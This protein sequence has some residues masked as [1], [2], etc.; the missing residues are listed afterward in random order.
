[1]PS[2]SVVLQCVLA[3]VVVGLCA[4]H[5]TG[6]RGGLRRAEAAWTMA[7]ALAL[8]A[9]SL[10]NGLL[11]VAPAQALEPL[12]LA[13]YLFV[14]V[15]L[16]VSV[17][18]VRLYA[19][20]Q[21]RAAPVVAMVVW[22]VAGAVLWFSTDLVFAHRWT[23]GLPV[24]GTL[25]T[26]TLLVPLLVVARTVQR[27]LRGRALDP[28]GGAVAL[29]ATASAVVLITSAVPPPSPLTELL[30]G[31]WVVPLVAVLL[32]VT[33]SRTAAVRRDAQRRAEMRDVLS[34][35]TNDAWLLRSPERTLERAVDEARR[36]LD[37]VTI[38]GTIRPLSR[39]RFVTELFSGSGRADDP[40]EAS[41]LRDLARVVSAA[42][43]RHALSTR[44]ERA[45][46]TDSLTGLHNRHA[47]DRHLQGALDRANVERSRVA[48]LF[49]DLD[50][51]KI[52]NDRHGHEW[53]DML[54]VHLAGHLR[55]VL[56]DGAFVARQG[57]DEFVA[58]L[59]RA[60]GGAAL[61]A[62]ARRLRD[63]FEGP[64]ESGARTAISVGL[65]VWRPG[66]VVDPAGLLREADLAMLEAKR[67]QA[68]VVLFDAS[69]RAR[70]SA[71]ATARHELE[72]GIRD[73][74]IVA[75][76]QPLNDA[77]TLEVVGL[78]VLARWRRNGRLRQ[79]AEWLPLAEETGLV[80]EI[81]RQMITAARAGMERFDLPVAVNVAARQLDEA[82]FVR[83]VEQAWGADRWDMLTIEVTESAL[84]YDA[85]HVRSSLTTLAA[86]GAR[87]A[88]D[89][90]GTGYNSL[91]RLGELPIHVLKIDRTFVHDIATPEGAAVLR[92]ILALA[93]AHGLEVVAEGVERVDELTALVD[94]GVPVVQGHMLGRPAARVPV[95]GRRPLSMARQPAS[96]ADLYGFVPVGQV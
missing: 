72:E 84:L 68:G 78:E 74:E 19:G 49:C 66:A 87:I 77:L 3:G 22:Y 91:S 9:V 69:M 58:V 16:V 59:D 60:P 79:P 75:H 33:A 47:L 38:T 39:D 8:A 73:G 34:T 27:S 25:W 30:A 63:E 10:T 46:F 43:E 55:T 57:G 11:G 29:G 45:A 32:V 85:A 50:G 64:G 14:A 54:L 86:K 81:G 31:L 15:A 61:T 83:H 65:A 82:D 18:A 93:E 42:A 37:D 71:R 89:D 2:W 35:V 23:D 40:V 13:R 52:A 28:V 70:V 20:R 88:L 92:A 17:P 51:F 94:M 12:L 96:R 6:W 1:M 95:R 36:L 5:A 41:F 76:F 4:L 21:P 48:V 62:L 24:Y 26:A 90:F 80:V 56:G 7:W 53:G 44:L 67:C